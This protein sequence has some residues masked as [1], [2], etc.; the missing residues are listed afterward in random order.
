MKE[1]IKSTPEKNVFWKQTQIILGKHAA[2]Q[3]AA[4]MGNIRRWFS[5]LEQ[6][7]GDIYIYVCT[8]IHM[9]CKGNCNS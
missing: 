1:V 2:Y 8:H 9:F 4:E 7:L 5:S 3:V 6:S